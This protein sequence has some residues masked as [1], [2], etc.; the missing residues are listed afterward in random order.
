M[1]FST[2]QI[3]LFA[4]AAL[5]SMLLVVAVPGAAVALGGAEE[6]PGVRPAA[7]GALAPGR[8]ALPML[9]DAPEILTLTLPAVTAGDPLNLPIVATGT[10]PLYFFGVVLPSGLSIDLTTG[11]ISGSITVAGDYPVQI[12]VSSDE[13]A[14]NGY[15]TLSVQPAATT[16]LTLTPSTTTPT[17]GDTIEID[18]VGYDAYDNSVGNLTATSVLTSDVASDIIVGNRITFPH[19]SPHTITAVAGGLSQSLVIQVKP[20]PAGLAVTGSVLTGWIAAVAVLALLLGGG[21][22]ALTRFRARLSR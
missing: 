13:G 22:L 19:A 5:A 17:Q 7:L 3:P 11:V 10:G 6:G 9:A 2:R 15:Y 21:A 16:R 18:V 12:E 20:L 1:P 14:D 8:G 4:S